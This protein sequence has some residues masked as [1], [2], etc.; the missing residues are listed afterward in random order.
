MS[1]IGWCCSGV[2]AGAPAL[3]SHHGL[4]AEA[5]DPGVASVVMALPSLQAAAPERD[6]DGCAGSLVHLVSPALEPRIGEC[7]DD[8]TNTRGGQIVRGTWKRGRGLRQPI[9]RV[10][11][12]LGIHAAAF[13]FAR[14]V[15]GVCGDPVERQER[16]VEDHESQPARGLRDLG[17]ARGDGGRGIYRL[18]DAAVDRRD[19]D[20]EPG[21]ELGSG[22]DAVQVGQDQQGLAARRDAPPPSADLATANSQV[23]GQLTHVRAGQT[24]ADG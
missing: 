11:Q 19:P 23:L 2:S 3:G 12:D 4:F 10:G 1:V 5:A 17:R 18:A 9:K 21:G 20:A 7:V 13:V 8:A 6:P 24:D 22:V 16:S 15:R 14:V